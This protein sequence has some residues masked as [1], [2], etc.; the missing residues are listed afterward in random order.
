MKASCQQCIKA[1][2]GKVIK[3][4]IVSTIKVG[5]GEKDCGF[6]STTTLMRVRW[7]A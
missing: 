2:A 1:M 7:V 6:K 3:P 4:T 5:L